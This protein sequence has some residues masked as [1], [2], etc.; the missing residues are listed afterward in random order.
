MCA[1]GDVHAADSVCVCFP[2]CRPRCRPLPRA[3]VPGAVR[4]QRD[5]P[6]GGVGRHDPGESAGALGPAGDRRALRRRV[7]SAG[8]VRPVRLSLA[9]TEG[10]ARRPPPSLTPWPVHKAT[11]RARAGGRTR[12]VP[13]RGGSHAPAQ[14]PPPQRG[15]LRGLCACPSKRAKPLNYFLIFHLVAQ[16]QGVTFRSCSKFPNIPACPA[17]PCPQLPP[18]HPANRP[19]HHTPTFGLLTFREH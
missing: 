14:E 19:L 16:P 5:G 13:E 15:T 1:D 17:L 11:W 18:T 6:A 10:R 2:R 7:G 8:D 12:Q 9:Q 3:L 4:P